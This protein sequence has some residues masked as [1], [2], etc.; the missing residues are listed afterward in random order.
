[1]TNFRFRET[2]NVKAVGLV[3]SIINYVN[4]ILDNSQTST[5]VCCVFKS[6][7]V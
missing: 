5:T 3:I 6:H 4:I 1:M 7:Q 2:V